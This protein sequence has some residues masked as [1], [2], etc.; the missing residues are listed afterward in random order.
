MSSGS[1]KAIAAASPVHAYVYCGS[2]RRSPRCLTVE[3]DIRRT[4]V[5]R[6]QACAPYRKCF[7]V[8][9]R[10]RYIQT[11]VIRILR[12]NRQRIPVCLVFVHRIRHRKRRGCYVGDVQQGQRRRIPR[13]CVRVDGIS[14]RR[15]RSDTV[16]KHIARS[17][18]HRKR[19]RTGQSKLTRFEHLQRDA[20]RTGIRILGAHRKRVLVRR[21]GRYRIRHRKRRGRY[22]V[23]HPVRP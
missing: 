23:G 2:S 18:V 15:T 4:L 7:L 20:Y 17:L 16:E 3:R 13:P 21:V 11:G 19:Y 8:Q 12:R 10:N 6:T 1:S 9:Y 5:D 22:V 14:P